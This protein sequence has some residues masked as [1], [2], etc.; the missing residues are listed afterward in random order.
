MALGDYHL[1]AVCNGKAFYDAE[2]TEHYL[3]MCDRNQVKALCNS[4]AESYQIAIVGK[5]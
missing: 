4:C 1:C 2:L 5:S 3:E